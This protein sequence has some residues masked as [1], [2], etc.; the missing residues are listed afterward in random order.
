MAEANGWRT[1]FYYQQELRS[2]EMNGI[3]NSSLVPGIYNADITISEALTSVLFNINIAAGTTFIF[4]SRMCTKDHR[5]YRQFADFSDLSKSEYYTIKATAETDVVAKVPLI[6]PNRE[7]PSR[8]FLV[9][10]MPYGP[11]NGEDPVFKL[12]IPIPSENRDNEPF[13]KE[14]DATGES[15]ILYDG[16]PESLENIENSEAYLIVGEFIRTGDAVSTNTNNA[17]EFSA[18]QKNYVFTRRGLEEYRYGYSTDKNTPALDFS[19]TATLNAIKIFWSSFMTNSILFKQKGDQRDA[20]EE[21]MRRSESASLRLAGDESDIVSGSGVVYD[22]IFAAFQDTYQDEYELSE[23]MTAT[24]YASVPTLYSCKWVQ[25][26]EDKDLASSNLP[27]QLSE[28]ITPQLSLLDKIAGR[29]ILSR[30]AT[31]IKRG[32]VIVYNTA[33]EKATD[34]S[35]NKLSAIIPVALVMRPFAGGVGINKCSVGAKPKLNPDFVISYFDL[36][37]GANEC[38]NIGLS[39]ENIYSTVSILD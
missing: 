17:L 20:Y 30:V 7:L 21:F 27:F 36:Y 39:A 15:K 32:D 24:D 29:P 23:L 25:T 11:N 3:F 13:L 5:Y 6:G 31:A 12:A 28:S 22:F 18:F 1:N 8:F 4:S 38:I 37:Q 2:A 19:Y 35:P 16:A 9:A 10:S 33:G 14:I 34:L 26:T